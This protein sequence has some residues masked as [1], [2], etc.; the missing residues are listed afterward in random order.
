MLW[1]VR[2]CVMLIVRGCIILPS[3][4]GQ[5]SALLPYKSCPLTN[6]VIS[7][8]RT[9]KRQRDGGHLIVEAVV[10]IIL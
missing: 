1:T 8:P 4:G 9:K 2:R 10:Y 7:A 6:W 5:T 3:L